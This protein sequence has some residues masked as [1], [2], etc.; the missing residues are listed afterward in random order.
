MDYQAKQMARAAAA[1]AMQAAFPKLV[2]VSDKN[3]PLIAAAKNMRIQ[4]AEA[5]P[6]IKFSVKSS[7]Y[8][9]GD[10]INV[11]WIDGPCGRQVDEIIK[12]YSAGSFDG[13]EDIYNYSPDA[14]N[15]AFGDAKYVFSQRENSDKAIESAL[16]TV[17]A[18]YGF[19]G[20]AKPSAAEYRA[21]R[22]CNVYPEG[23]GAFDLRDLVYQVAAARTWALNK[24]PKAVELEEAAS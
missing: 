8:S 21:G 19:D 22:C 20:A 2:A 10:S 7:R 5:F 16:R 13:M 9:G 23:G 18:K 17:F 1:K 12:R 24:A 6:G 15:D 14:W 4:L 11:S 3:N